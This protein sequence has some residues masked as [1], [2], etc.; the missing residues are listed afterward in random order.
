MNYVVD[1]K[2]HFDKTDADDI[3]MIYLTE[4]DIL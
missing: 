4:G 2:Y 3:G 1:S